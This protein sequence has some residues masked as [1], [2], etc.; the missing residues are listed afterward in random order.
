MP[1]SG[2]DE[3]ERQQ[4]AVNLLTGEGAHLP[5]SDRQTK[6]GSNSASVTLVTFMA[7][8][9]VIHRDS[10]VEITASSAIALLLSASRYSPN[11]LSPDQPK[12]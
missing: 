7:S 2:S 11:F 4:S 9:T 10:I 8:E 6:R 1:G 5:E 3:G 12:P